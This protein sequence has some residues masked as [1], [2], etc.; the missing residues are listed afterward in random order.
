MKD[1]SLGAPGINF[2]F[3]IGDSS[4]NFP[5]TD[6]NIGF[7]ELMLTVKKASET[8]FILPVPP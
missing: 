1:Q 2:Q 8:E 5:R 6:D 4:T 3:S 7:F